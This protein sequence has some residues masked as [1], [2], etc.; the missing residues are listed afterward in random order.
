MKKL[1]ISI[2]LLSLTA[3]TACGGGG[4]GGGTVAP[5]ASTETFPLKAIYINAVIS[6]SS[7][8]FT[9]SGTSSGVAVTGSGTVTSSNL[10]AGTFEGLSAL[11]GTSTLTGSFVANGV[12][13]PLNFVGISWFDSNYVP[14]GTSSNSEYSV[15]VGTPT[16]PITVRINDTGTLYTEN[17]YT[18]STKAVFLGTETESYVLEADTASTA[19]LTIISVEKNKSGITTNTGTDQYR[20]TPTGTFKRIKST[21]VGGPTSLEFTF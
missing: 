7:E 10:S 5:V 14:K 18:S 16:I 21:N 19:L 20:I 3:L 8:N 13:Y 9:I 1:L 4:G 15:I 6:P 12:T 2:S 11:Q 17:L